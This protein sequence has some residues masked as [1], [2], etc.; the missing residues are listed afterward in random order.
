MLGHCISYGSYQVGPKNKWDF[1]DFIF[2]RGEWCTLCLQV[3]SN[4]FLCHAALLPLTG[5]RYIESL[6][7]SKRTF[8]ISRYFIYHLIIGVIVYITECCYHYLLIIYFTFEVFSTLSREWLDRLSWLE[9]DPQEWLVEVVP[10]SKVPLV[11]TSISMSPQQQVGHCCLFHLR[12][13]SH[14]LALLFASSKFWHLHWKKELCYL[15]LAWPPVG[16]CTA[17]VA[18]AVR[19]FMS[20]FTRCWA[21]LHSTGMAGEVVG[22]QRTSL[23][24]ILDGEFILMLWVVQWL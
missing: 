10:A 14:Y 15:T 9:N 24:V 17:P 2:V 13:L 12:S 5:D 16:I 1:L 3:V 18:L 8:T 23:R 11:E 20:H 21:A 7:P 4:Y 6:E 22:W 19:W